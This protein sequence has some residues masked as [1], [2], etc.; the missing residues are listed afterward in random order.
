MEIDFINIVLFVSNLSLAVLFAFSI[1]YVFWVF[2]IFYNT[3][4][5]ISSISSAQSVSSVSAVQTWAPQAQVFGSR[6]LQDYIV[7]SWFLLELS[8]QNLVLDLKYIKRTWPPFLSYTNLASSLI[9]LSKPSV[10][11]QH[12]QKNNV[13]VC[14]FHWRIVKK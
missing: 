7:N 5:S 2:I 8:A 9:F 1:I 6:Y 10:F 11:S 12:Y 4:L 3:I 14:S 13:D